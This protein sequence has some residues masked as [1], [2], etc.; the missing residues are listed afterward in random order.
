MTRRKLGVF[1][2][3]PSRPREKTET[4]IRN[5]IASA[6]GRIDGVW[7]HVNTIFEGETKRKGYV[8]CGLG[9]GSPDMVGAV[10]CAGNFARF[11]A[12]ELKSKA[13]HVNEADALSED[14]RIWHA[15]M[16]K[17][18]GFVAT[19]WSAEEAVAAVERCRRGER[20]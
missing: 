1:D 9:E 4:D 8:T 14:Q 15:M 16:R 19:V 2:I 11:F 20:E 5:E 7:I 12:L 3:D 18:G 13:R 6:L 17:I 10:Q